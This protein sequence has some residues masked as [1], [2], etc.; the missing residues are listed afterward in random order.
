MYD[1][2]RIFNPIYIEIRDLESFYPNTQPFKPFYS[3]FYLFTNQPFADVA[4]Q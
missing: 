4:P 2:I 3:Y 1:K